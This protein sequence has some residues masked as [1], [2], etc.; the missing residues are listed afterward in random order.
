[1]SGNHREIL[2]RDLFERSGKVTEHLFVICV[3]L[4]VEGANFLR[5]G[6]RYF[7]FHNADRPFIGA[8][9]L[10]EHIEVVHIGQ[11]VPGTGNA[12]KRVVKEPRILPSCHARLPDIFECI[13][14]HPCVGAGKQGRVLP[15]KS[16]LLLLCPESVTHCFQAELCRK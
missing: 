14:L 11:L 8:K 5:S 12:G 9:L 10:V 16:S 13:S 1:M 7:I 3:I 2:V 4:P 15:V 6:D